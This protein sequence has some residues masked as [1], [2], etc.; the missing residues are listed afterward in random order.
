MTEL[1]ELQAG[2]ALLKSRADRLGLDLVA[3]LLR[4]AILDL[5]AAIKDADEEP[6]LDS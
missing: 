5:E 6:H 2:V 1:R 4:M 3:T